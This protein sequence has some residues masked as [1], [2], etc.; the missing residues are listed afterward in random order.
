MP[1]RAAAP[2]DEHAVRRGQGFE[3]VRRC[4]LDDL[5]VVTAELCAVFVQQGNRL[6]LALDRV[7]QPVGRFPRQLE[8]HRARARAHVPDRVARLH[9]KAADRHPAHL[10]LGHRHFCAGEHVVPHRLISICRVRML[11]QQHGQI[12]AGLVRQRFRFPGLDALVFRAEVFAEVHGQA[13]EARVR[14]H[15][16]HFGGGIFP[17][18]KHKGLFM[19]ADRAE[20]AAHAPVQ[21][22]HAGVVIR[23]AELCAEILHAGQAADQPHRAMRRKLPPQPPGGAEKAH[24]ARNQH[25]NRLRIGCDGLRGELVERTD[26]RTVTNRGQ[27]P[28]GEHRARRRERVRGLAGQAVRRAHAGADDV[29]FAGHMLPSYSK[30]TALGRGDPLSPRGERAAARGGRTTTR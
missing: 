28:G 1:H 2:A 23:N 29:E 8:R 26:C 13:A 16:A 24:V 17:A 7:Y 11:D 20:D 25:G 18:R 9:R 12:A 27:P 19:V 30:L 4:A 14:K 6:G 22:A 3:R 15:S 21:A 5:H 10:F